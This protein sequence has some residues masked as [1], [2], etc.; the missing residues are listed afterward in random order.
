MATIL[1]TTQQFAGA[2]VVTHTNLNNIIGGASFVTGSSGTTDD[3]TLEVDAS[4]GFLKVKDI[5]TAQLKDDSVTTSKILDSNVTKAKL[6]DISG[7]LKVLGRTTAG[8]G[9]PEEVTINNDVDLTT[10]SDITLATDESI[11]NFINKLKPNFS[12]LIFTETYV[13]LNPDSQYHEFGTEDDPFEVSITPRFVNS[14]IRFTCSISSSTNNSSHPNFFKLQRR[15]G[16]ASET[17]DFADVTD[18]MGPDSGDRTRASFCSSYPG[19]YAVSVDGMDY[20]D[21]PTYIE[22]DEI[23]YRVLVYGETTV[24]IYINRASGDSSNDRVPSLISTAMVEEV[25]Q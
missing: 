3:I 2:D 15:V 19:L 20:V 12:Q 14:K 6:E 4:G 11:K 21:N 24:D 23:T 7:P 8:A 22:G 1:N 17:N 25:F 10:A 13:N 16:P 18:A 9:A 5:D